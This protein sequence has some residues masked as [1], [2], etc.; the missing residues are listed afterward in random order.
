MNKGHR[1]S[2]ARASTAS[3]DLTSSSDLSSE[4]REICTDFHRNNGTIANLG[5]TLHPAGERNIWR[6]ESAH[7]VT[8]RDFAAGSRPIEG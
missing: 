7:D 2:F 1:L 3:S 4:A 8:A 6:A 5:A